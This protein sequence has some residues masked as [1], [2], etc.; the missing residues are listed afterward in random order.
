MFET[1]TVER[2]Q[3]DFTQFNVWYAITQPYWNKFIYNQENNE[4][5]ETKPLRIKAVT[6]NRGTG[7]VDA[8]TNENKSIKINKILSQWLRREFGLV[9]GF[10]YNLH[11]VAEINYYTVVALRNIHSLHTNLFSFSALVFMGL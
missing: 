10:T 4:K 8:T 1:W 7:A 9:I 5:W 3:R 2:I 6:Q 11:V